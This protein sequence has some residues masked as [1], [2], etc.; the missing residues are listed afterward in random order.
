MSK[1]R[2]YY[3]EHP[4]FHV[5]VDSIIFG[6]DQG[7][8]KLL[9]HKRQFEPA[10]GEWSLFGGFVQKDESLDAAANRILFELTGLD[11]VYME[12][13]QAYGEVSRDPA[14]RVISVTYYALI[15]AKEF[16]EATSSQYGATWVSLKDLPTLIMDHN[17]MVKKGLRRLKRRAAS[18][19]IGFELLPREFTM[20]QL[21]ALYEAIYQAEL[22]KRNFRK[23]I[24]AMDVLIKLD[25]KDKSSSRKGA[26]LYRFDQKKYRKLVDG[27]YNFTI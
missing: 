8:L 20:P 9:I 2:Q 23:K 24:L 6:F 17:L 18:Q 25:M 5:A 13:L 11:K 4:T 14:D 21:Q 7:E 10:K 26:F 15:P 27:G 3:S 12:E 16:T 1:E 19:P 22:D